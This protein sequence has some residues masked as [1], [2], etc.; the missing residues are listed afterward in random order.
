M[1]LLFFFFFFFIRLLWPDNL[2]FIN[3]FFSSSNFKQ[4]T[5]L[6]QNKKIYIF[7]FLNLLMEEKNYL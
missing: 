3:F 6:K 7:S 2:N 5:C 4:S 1:Q